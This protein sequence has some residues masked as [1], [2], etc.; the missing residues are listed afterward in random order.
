MYLLCFILL[1]YYNVHNIN[2]NTFY[3][4]NNILFYTHNSNIQDTCLKHPFNHI[5]YFEGYSLISKGV[6][7]SSIQHE[8]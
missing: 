5:A 6:S 1:I 7:L 8:E 2:N 4:A 3:L